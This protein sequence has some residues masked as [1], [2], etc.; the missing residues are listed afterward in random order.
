[1]QIW[2]SFKQ[3]A[4]GY[5][6]YNG[7]YTYYQ[8]WNYFLLGSRVVYYMHPFNTNRIELYA[9]GL[10]GYYITGFMF[11]SNDPH[12]AEPTDPGNYL[13]INHYPNYFTGSIFA[14]VRSW[15]SHSGS[16][17]AELG[18]GYITANVGFSYKI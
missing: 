2:D 12:F 3:I 16:V 9:G 13:S 17:W 6:D 14:G 1:M 5:S 18:C 15:F 8:V 11:K 7:L 10:G 4:T